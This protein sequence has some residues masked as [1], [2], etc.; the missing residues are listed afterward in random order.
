MFD[1]FR[2]K[3]I[4]DSGIFAGF[5]DFHSHILPSVDDGVKTIEEAM[6]VLNAYQAL[7]V[8]TVILTPHVMEDYPLNKTEY[9]RSQFYDFK[10]QYQ[11]SIELLLGAEYMLDNRFDQLLQEDDLLPI[12]DKY[13]LVESNCIGS[14]I[15]FKKRLDLIYAKGYSVI[16]AHPERYLYMQREDYIKLKEERVLFQLNLLSILGGYGKEVEKRSR[17]L[18]YADAYNCIGTDIH[19]LNYHMNN[20]KRCKLNKKDIKLLLE[21]KEKSRWF[22][23][24]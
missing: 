18:L 2:Y 4:L 16:L 21:I 17:E 3:T 7:N 1:C 12:R 24:K 6:H 5:I 10:R 15:S 20:Y 11:G 14:L 13:L 22:L 19:S 23:N 8:K 9:L